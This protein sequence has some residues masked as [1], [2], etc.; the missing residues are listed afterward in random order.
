MPASNPEL[1]TVGILGAGRVGTAV[2]RQAMKAGFDVKIATAKP[3]SDIEL[4]VEVVTPGAKAVDA[5][6]AATCDVVV[7]AIPLHKFRTLDPGLL[8]GKIVID[9]MNYWAITDGTVEDI[10][11]APSSSEAIQEHL[12]ESFVVKS[13]NHIGYQDIEADARLDDDGAR[14]ALAVASDHP[15][16]KQLVANFISTV[17]FDVVDA[18]NLAAGRAFQPGTDI[19]N[20]SHTADQMQE[21][22]TQAFARA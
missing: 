17:G 7:V 15:E 11:K 18:G 20:G 14:R 16:A 10:E 13:F 5:A 1:Q 12:A 21:L 9:A 8:A 4:I 2:A 22:L 19:F 3:A 6:E